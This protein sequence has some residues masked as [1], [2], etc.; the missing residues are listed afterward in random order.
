MGEKIKAV[1]VYDQR[2]PSEALKNVLLRLGVAVR[3]IRN[4][5][6]A[7]RHFRES[8]GT[9]LVFTNKNLS[10]GTWEDILRLAQRSNSFLPVVVVSRLLDTDLCL[11]A[12]ESGAFNFITPPFLS[13]DVANVTGSAM[14][15]KLVSRNLQPA[16]IA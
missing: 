6:E 7:S 13:I 12:L 4:C 3:H 16:Y 11:K 10:D 2:D 8:S 15:Q 9:E 1:M 14:Y 5:Y